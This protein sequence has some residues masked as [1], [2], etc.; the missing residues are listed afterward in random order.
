MTSLHLIHAR[1]RQRRVEDE[2]SRLVTIAALR[3][4]LSRVMPGAVVW[5]YGSLIEP[6]RFNRY[7]DIDIAVEENPGGETMEYLQSLIAS[8]TGYVV[9]IC[10]IDRSRL[11]SRIRQSGCR[12]TV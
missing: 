10:Q 1:D 3:E 12:W 7:S 4:V 8:E 6:G 5:V 11:E 9:D 2:R